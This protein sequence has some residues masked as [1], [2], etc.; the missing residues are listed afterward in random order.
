M[1]QTTEGDEEGVNDGSR[2]LAEALGCHPLQLVLAARTCG[3]SDDFCKYK[4]ERDEHL[5]EEKAPKGLETFL[6]VTKMSLTKAVKIIKN[7]L[8]G[9]EDDVKK[10]AYFL[11]YCSPDRI[12][13]SLFE[14]AIEGKQYHKPISFA[15]SGN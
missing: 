11:S 3:D 7:E 2:A 12:P 5:R 8:G 6:I 15:Q 4:E 9:N 13:C 14:N 1:G 10:L